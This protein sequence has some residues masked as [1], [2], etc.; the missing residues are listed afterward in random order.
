MKQIQ[1]ARL[2]NL[3]KI[4]LFMGLLK[5]LYFRQIKITASDRRFSSQLGSIKPILMLILSFLV[6]TSKHA[7]AEFRPDLRGTGVHDSFERHRSATEQLLELAQW[8][9]IP[10]QNISES[11]WAG[12]ISPS[13]TDIK[14]LEAENAAETFRKFGL[15][16]NVSEFWWN[17]LVPWSNIF[18]REWLTTQRLVEKEMASNWSYRFGPIPV[19]LSALL[20]C[21]RFED[22]QSKQ[23]CHER[24]R[25]EVNFT[26]A[27][28]AGRSSVNWFNTADDPI[29]ALLPR[30]ERPSGITERYLEIRQ[31]IYLP[32]IFKKLNDERLE[33]LEAERR[34]QLELENAAKKARE[35]QEMLQR[36]QQQ[37]TQE[38]QL[39]TATPGEAFLIF[40]GN[41]VMLEFGDELGCRLYKEFGFRE[42]TECSAVAR[43]KIAYSVENHTYIALL[44]GFI[45]YAL[46]PTLVVIGLFRGA[47]KSAWQAFSSVLV[48]E[49]FEGSVAVAGQLST[50]GAWD[51]ALYSL[52]LSIGL[53][54]VHGTVRAVAYLWIN[55]FVIQN[56]ILIFIVTGIFTVLYYYQ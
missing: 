25:N 20:F 18:G 46:T 15:S 24:Y 14:R 10:N 32:I 6:L 5:A 45:G 19:E 29:F 40:F 36:L 44:G 37:P 53:G 22:I 50:D 8:L 47:P 30:H 49:L 41:G 23:A 28:L 38:E 35:R 2:N 21:N 39:A 48:V 7:Y 4:S 54:L 56:T 1:S 27:I 33:R 3:K 43:A 11:M 16:Y 42:Q 34:Q 12:R 9:N 51:T 55:S 31:S 52:W 13:E 26:S 17:Q